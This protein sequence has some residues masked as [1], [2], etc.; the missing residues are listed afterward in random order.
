MEVAA[1]APG[2]PLYLHGVS[3]IHGTLPALKVLFSG[4]AWPYRYHFPEEWVT[5]DCP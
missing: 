2:V 3:L 4:F 5:I 1:G